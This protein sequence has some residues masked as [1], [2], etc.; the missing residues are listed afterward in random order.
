MAGGFFLWSS[1]LSP[2]ANLRIDYSRVAAERAK[3]LGSGQ[4]VAG[5]APVSDAVQKETQVLTDRLRGHPGIEGLRL[6]V[7]SYHPPSGT[8]P[9]EVA[10]N[11]ELVTSLA[12]GVFSHLIAARPRSSGRW[13]GWDCWASRLDTH[14][15]PSRRSSNGSRRPRLSS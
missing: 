1:W 7:E 2:K 3:E 8:S 4:S 10:A 6:L 5:A 14:S 13:R 12:D 15:T 9:A 11:R